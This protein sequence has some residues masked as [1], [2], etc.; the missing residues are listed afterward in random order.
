MKRSVLLSLV[1]LAAVFSCKVQKQNVTT[2]NSKLEYVRVSTK[3]PAYFETT[4]NQTWVPVMINYIVPQGQNETAAFTTIENYFRNFSNNGGNSMRIWISSPFLEIEDEKAGQYSPVK[5][6]RIDKLLQLAEK[7]KIR[8]KFTLQHIRTISTG[9]VKQPW[10][11]SAVLSV[12]NGGPFK[13][14]KEYITTATGKKYYIDR[15][16]ALAGRYRDNA[17]IFGWELWNEMDAV[18]TKDWFGFTSEVLDSVKALFPHHLV[19]QTLGSLH[20]EDAARRYEQFFTLQNNPYVSLHRYID[21]GKDWQQYDNITRPVDSLVY[22]AVQFARNVVH[23]RP[24]VVNEIGAVEA[25]HAGPSKIYPQDSAGVLIHDMIFAP[26]FCGAAGTGGMWHWDSYVQRQN[27]WHHY[28]RFQNAIKG[29]DPVKEQFSPFSL[30]KQGVT[31]YGLKGKSQT[32][33]WCRNA[34]NNWK[35]EFINHITPTLKTGFS[36]QL[37]ETGRTS[38]RTALVY[39]PWKDQWTAV[40]IKDGVISVPPFL[41]S[42]VIVIK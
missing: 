14:I 6:A 19:T 31:A 38:A 34:E 7:Y 24:V 27:L 4:D 9:Q 12:D 17:Q 33:I 8:I 23:D 13:N 32:M 36:L 3:Y 28:Q 2:T 15:V 18:D 22:D 42:V 37:A 39:D 29:V 40:A 25:N 1:L 26:F 41:R 16:R 20:S 10:A 30:V 21:P 5:L 35:T 11:N